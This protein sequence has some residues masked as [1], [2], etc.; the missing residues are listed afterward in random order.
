MGHSQ[1]HL[2]FNGFGNVIV[3]Q[4]IRCSFGFCWKTG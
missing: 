1:H 3:N 2:L 4:S